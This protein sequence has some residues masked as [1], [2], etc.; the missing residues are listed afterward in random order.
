MP[1]VLARRKAEPTEKP[2]HR[3]GKIGVMELVKQLGNV[4]QACN[5]GVLT[6]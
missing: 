3:R 6:R 2:I 1:G 5:D 4:S